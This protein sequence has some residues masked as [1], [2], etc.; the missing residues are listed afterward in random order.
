MSSLPG[1]GID[2]L[3]IASPRRAMRS[4]ALNLAARL[5]SGAAA[6]ALAVLTA[7]VL[8]T[9][10]RGAYV[11]LTTAAGVGVV[12]LSAPAPVMVATSLS[13]LACLLRKLMTTFAPAAAK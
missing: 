13:A 12:V 8:D 6:F 10:G 2:E 5:T 3:P 1:G 4:G 11:V 9:H 7:R